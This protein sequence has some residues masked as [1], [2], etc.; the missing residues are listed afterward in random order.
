MH[1]ECWRR[2]LL[3]LSVETPRFSSTSNI[4]PSILRLGAR[5]V[6]T[7]CKVVTTN[8]FVRSHH[9]INRYQPKT[10]W[11]SWNFIDTAHL[12]RIASSTTLGSEGRKRALRHDA[13]RRRTSSVLSDWQPSFP[14]RRIS[15]KDWSISSFPRYRAARSRKT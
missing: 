3:Y 2:M 6:L 1:A 9:F 12:R 11:I 8:S 15:R 13:S 4:L 10:I 14:K 5:P 7:R